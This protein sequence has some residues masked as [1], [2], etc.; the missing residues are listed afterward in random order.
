MASRDLEKAKKFVKDTGL[1]GGRVAVYGN[2]DQLLEDPRVQAEYIPLP[3]GV[4]CDW[5]RKAAAKGKHVMSEKP[6]ALV[7]ACE[8]EAARAAPE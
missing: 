8:P 7:S 6:I 1:E 4:R 3:S 5:V 2:Y